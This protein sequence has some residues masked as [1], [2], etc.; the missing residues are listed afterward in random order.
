MTGAARGGATAGANHLGG[1]E[2]IGAGLML[3]LPLGR[4]LDPDTGEDWEGVGVKPDVVVPAAEAL[5]S[6]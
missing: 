3:W 5:T 4:T 1:P 6:R 2:P